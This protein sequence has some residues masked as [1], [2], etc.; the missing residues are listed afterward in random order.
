MAHTLRDVS[1]DEAAEAAQPWL[2]RAL[3]ATEHS[4]AKK[5]ASTRVI[6]ASDATDAKGERDLLLAVAFA[7]PRDPEIRFVEECHGYF[8]DGARVPL[9]VSGLWGKYFS[10]FDA[11]ATV[12]R[13]IDRW[14]R[15]PRNKYYD[16]LK[17]LDA[18]HV[19]RSEQGKVIMAG[20]DLNGDRQSALG[21]AMHRAIELTLNDEPIPEEDADPSDTEPD[22]SDPDAPYWTARRTFATVFNLEGPRLSWLT[23][24]A[25]Q[26]ALSKT[27]DAKVIRGTEPLR[28]HTPEFEQFTRWWQSHEDLAPLRTEWS[29]WARDL[30][31]AGQID[32]IFW[33]ITTGEIVMVDWKRSRELQYFT[34]DED[35]REF[36]AVR[37]DMDG[38]YMHDATGKPDREGKYMPTVFP[39][40]SEE[41]CYGKAPFD[42]VPNTNF[43]HYV[44]Q[45]NMYAEILRRYYGITVAR[46][47]LLRLHPN[48]EE[49]QMLLVPDLSREVQVV[50]DERRKTCAEEAD[51]AARIQRAFRKHVWRK[52]VLWN[53]DTACGRFFT[54]L[55][56][57]VQSRRAV[58]KTPTSC[59]SYEPSSPSSSSDAS[60]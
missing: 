21:T 50:F 26:A 36:Y 60:I 3:D 40:S 44:L 22:E 17:A 58:E 45:Q 39:G 24:A 10:H 31:L 25:R 42:K 57:A 35:T 7:H 32:S 19:P 23:N 48:I 2:G 20:W 53:P 1:E 29:V 27:F 37:T 15:N 11:P 51:A 12:K 16:V 59:G 18:L 43:G 4:Q 33:S 34:M 9:S 41:E 5:R 46:M 49:A 13:S 56:A 38:K 28:T 55:L 54:K 52:R 6:A 30:R 8:L 14:R 47:Y